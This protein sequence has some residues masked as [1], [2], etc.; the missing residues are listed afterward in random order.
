MQ[1]LALPDLESS[2]EQQ[3]YFQYSGQFL[4]RDLDVHTGGSHPENPNK[5]QIARSDLWSSCFLSKRM[6]AKC[7][8]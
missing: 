4:H 3:Y 7:C 6:S 1:I 5:A 2:A 8:L